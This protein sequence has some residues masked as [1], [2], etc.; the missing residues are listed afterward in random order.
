MQYPNIYQSPRM[1]KYGIY[2]VIRIYI[3]CII[4]HCVEVL[5]LHETLF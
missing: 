3:R 1:N 5:N 4:E 2:C